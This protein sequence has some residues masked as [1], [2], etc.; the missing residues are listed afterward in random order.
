V[1]IIMQGAEGRW[2][3]VGFG[4]ISMDDLPYA[5]IVDGFGRVAERKLEDHGPGRLLPPTLRVISSTVQGG[6]RTV[7]LRRAAR[8]ATPDYFTFAAGEAHLPFISV[9]GGTPDFG[10]HVARGSSAVPLL[11]VGAPTCICRRSGG[12]IDGVPYDPQCAAWP[13]SDLARNSN[14][15]CDVRTYVG[16]MACC[17]DGNFLL[18]A[19]QEVP[20]YVDEV[21][22]KWRFYFEDWD[23]RR[24]VQAVHLEWALNGCD[25]GGGHAGC[26]HI[27]YDV[28]KAPAGTPPER[29]VHA[30]HARFRARAMFTPCDARAEAY[31]ADPRNVTSAGV[32]LVMAGGHC[33]APACLSLELWNEDSGELLCRITPVRGAG[34]APQDEAGYLWLPHCAWGDAADGLRPPPV[35]HL[36]TNLRAIKRANST[37]YH[38]GVMAIWQMRGAFL[39]EPGVFV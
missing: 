34:D 11:Q 9:V 24:H 15:T 36:G 17:R 3:G 19:D 25:S 39:P 5:V 29:A 38:Y 7:A 33:H 35:L 20:G 8:G 26:R 28:P 21:Y 22:F 10:A 4:A 30:V 32:Q 23:P 27:E 14:P 1:T 31:C 16:G 12:T 2:F 6:K 18:D 13:L 37:H